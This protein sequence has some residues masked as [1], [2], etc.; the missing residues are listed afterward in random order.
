LADVQR[1]EVPP[2]T[3][4]TYTPQVSGSFAQSTV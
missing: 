3:A 2:E 4:K 1:L